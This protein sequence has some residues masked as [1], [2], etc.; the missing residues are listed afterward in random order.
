M[1]APSLFEASLS[2][3]DR[4]HFLPP[5]PCMLDASVICGRLRFLSF[6]PK[7]TRNIFLKVGKRVSAIWGRALVSGRK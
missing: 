2:L 5:R 4:G 1:S 6:Q 3:E 7:R